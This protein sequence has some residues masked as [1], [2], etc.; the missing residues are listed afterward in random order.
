MIDPKLVLR[1]GRVLGGP[2]VLPRFCSCWLGK[3]VYRCGH[4]HV[5]DACTGELP[6][7]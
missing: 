4:V 5:W 3:C 1:N 7:V 2:L 6:I